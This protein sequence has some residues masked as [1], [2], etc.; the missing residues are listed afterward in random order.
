MKDINAFGVF[1]QML[2]KSTDMTIDKRLS[3]CI[4]YVKAGEAF[5]QMCNFPVEDGCAYTIVRTVFKQF[6][7]LGRDLDK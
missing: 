7:S 5:T 6:E 2:D 1:S 4:W 3:I